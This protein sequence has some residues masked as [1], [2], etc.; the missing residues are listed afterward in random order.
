MEI[1]NLLNT[2]LDS[3]SLSICVK[4]IEAGVNPEA[5]AMVIKE[6]QR[7]SSSIQVSILL[8]LLLSVELKRHCSVCLLVMQVSFGC[9]TS[10]MSIKFQFRCTVSD[11]ALLLH[12][13]LFVNCKE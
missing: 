4:L 13:L 2:G 6:L 12:V 1:S 9:I 8:L 3:E 10:R 11:T 5:L 7:E